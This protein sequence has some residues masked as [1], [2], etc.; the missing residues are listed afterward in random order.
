MGFLN[1]KV[2]SNEKLQKWQGQDQNPYEEAPI[3]QS[4]VKME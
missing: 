4:L 3:M 1:S 2:I